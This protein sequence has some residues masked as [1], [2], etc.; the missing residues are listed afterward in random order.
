[1]DFSFSTDQQG[2]KTLATKA[3]ADKRTAD[4]EAVWGELA[5]AGLLGVALPADHGGSGLGVLELCL[6]LEQAGRAATPAP[7]PAVLAGA[8]AIAQFGTPALAEQLLPGVISGEQ[9]ISIALYEVGGEPERPATRA[10][11]DGSGWKLEGVKIAVP[12]LARAATVIVPARLPDGTTGLFLVA[13]NAAGVRRDRETTTDDATLH[14][15]TLTGVHVTDADQLAPNRGDAALAWL[16]DRVTISL[17]AFELGIAQKQLEMT[18]EYAVRRK[19]FGKPIGTF[20]AVA[21]RA[22]DMH[23][24]VESMRLTVWQ[25]AFLLAEGRSAAAELATAAFW[26]AEAGPRIA[27]GAQHIH[28]GMGFDRGY[29]LY[30]YF[31]AAKRLEL[32]LGGANRALARLG[33]TLAQ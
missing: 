18:A 31:L 15:L 1:M 25:A 10:E 26:A 28:G 24:D 6:V 5:R 12:A 3:F 14:Q 23:I 29:P 32:E 17:C 7:L 33:A 13:P 4:P 11:R 2:L 16:L 9:L 8:A 20:Q 22:A 19:Q 21:Q 27:V 30:R